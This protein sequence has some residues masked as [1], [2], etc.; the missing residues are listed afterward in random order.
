MTADDRNPLLRSRSTLVRSGTILS[1]LDR[2]QPLHRAGNL[3]YE[4]QGTVGN[5]R[6]LWQNL[7]IFFDNLIREF[8]ELGSILILGVAISTAFQVFLPQSQLFQW[9]QTPLTQIIIMVF[10]G[11]VLSFNSLWSPYFL[12]PLLSSFLSGSSLVF[13][14]FNS[15]FN[16]SSLILLFSIMR[17]KVSVYLIILTA[18][19]ILILG[20]ILNFYIG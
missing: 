7:L 8:I 18:E 6:S 2:S 20:L 12:T 3:I 14:S 13:L 11:L 5:Y 17:V 1:P 10:F 15:L 16:I 4:Y 19:L 9:G